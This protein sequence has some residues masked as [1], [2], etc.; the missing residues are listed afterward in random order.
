RDNS[1][2]AAHYIESLKK[3]VFQ[4]IEYFMQEEAELVNLKLRKP[5]AIE[6]APEILKPLPKPPNQKTALNMIWW[7]IKMRYWSFRN[8]TFN[9]PKDV[10]IYVLY[11]SPS[12]Y[13]IDE[14][15]MGLK[16]GKIGIV[17]APADIRLE[18]NNNLIITHEMLH[19][20]GATDKYDYVSSMPLYPHG[21]AD[22]KRKPIYP[23][24][25]AEIM[26]GRIPLSGSEIKWPENLHEVIIGIKTCVEI[27]WLA[28]NHLKELEA[29]L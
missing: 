17:N 13:Q 27:N 15:S 24:E 19:T 29:E 21:L 2:E 6:I 5:V 4:P 10:R 9:P 16:K 8:D 12:N 11:S 14:A 1:D 23:Q 22:P 20:F 25:M 3:R 26:A 18:N 7:T 28:E